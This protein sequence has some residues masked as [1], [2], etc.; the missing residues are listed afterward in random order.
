MALHTSHLSPVYR[1]Q[2]IT[3][4]SNQKH[5]VWQRKEEEIENQDEK[6]FLM[7]TTMY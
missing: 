1:F 4:Q 2:I 3:N 5:H 6:V 7:T